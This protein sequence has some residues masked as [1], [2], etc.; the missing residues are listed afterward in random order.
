M[1]VPKAASLDSITTHANSPAAVAPIPADHA[2]AAL[3][4]FEASRP[5][6]YKSIAPAWQDQNLAE[7]ARFVE[8]PVI[9]GHVR[10]ASPGSHVSVENCHPFRFGRLVFMHNGHV[11][12]FGRIKRALVGRLSAEAYDSIK[13]LTDS[14]HVFALVVTRL[15]DPLRPAPFEPR[16][17]AAALLAAMTEIHGLLADFGIDAGFT[18]FN[19]ALT[20]GE[21]VVTSRFCDKWPEIPPPSLYFAYATASQVLLGK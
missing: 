13:G 5:F 11:E 17:L 15:Q 3:E 1:V 21:T 20:D 9:F 12:C 2:A 16:E 4:E 10:A 19:F 8:S 6:M 18:T 7:L 14:E